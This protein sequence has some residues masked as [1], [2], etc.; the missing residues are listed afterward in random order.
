MATSLP[1]L[2]PGKTRRTDNNSANYMRA[3]LPSPNTLPPL[4]TT[5]GSPDS[6]QSVNL[7]KAV[8]G[9]KDNAVYTTKYNLLTFLPIVR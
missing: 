6:H 9:G 7:G 1:P 4:S 5:E 2:Q 3:S 8:N